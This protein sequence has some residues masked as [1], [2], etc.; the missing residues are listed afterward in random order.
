MK[1]T[2]IDLIGQNGNDALVYHHLHK[3]GHRP[4]KG[5]SP[6]YT[7][8]TS[9]KK[10]CLHPADDSYEFYGG[11]GIQ[12]CGRWLDFVNFLADMGERPT[13]CTIDRIDPDGD[14][15][16]S[17]CRW[18]TQREQTL[19]RGNVNQVKFRGEL[20]TLKDISVKYGVPQTTVYRRWAQGVRGDDLV[21]GKNRNA[22]RVG[23][24]NS[25]SKLTESDVVGIRNM[26]LLGKTQKACADKYQVSQSVIS[27]IFTGKTWAHVKA[28]YNEIKPYQD[29]FEE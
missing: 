29:D 18:A 28:D 17:N 7:S 23:E 27:N 24:R 8:W 21:S 10:R 5:S 26:L 20:L 15:E 14:Y 16:P 25:S 11:K 12:I 9:M 13:G 2:R 19:N 3:H 6:T 1:L 22:L 4:K